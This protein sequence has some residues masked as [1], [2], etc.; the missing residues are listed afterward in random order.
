A[1]HPLRVSVNISTRHLLDA[2][3]LEDLQEML[4]KYPGL[5]PELVE[6]EITESAPLRD[7]LEAQRLLVACHRLGVR[8]A[9][10]DFGT[11]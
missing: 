5:R 10:D 7:M 3:F 4:A 6:I 2:R 9:L 8:V 1:G 11:G